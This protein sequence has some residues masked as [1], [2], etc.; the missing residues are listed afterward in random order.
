MPEAQDAA[1]NPHALPPAADVSAR[2]LPGC[3]MLGDEGGACWPLRIGRVWP[4]V[5]A[6]RGP[7]H[8]RYDLAGGPHG[9]EADTLRRMLDPQCW[10]TGW[11]RLL[12]IGA[13]TAEGPAWDALAALAGDGRIGLRVL[14]RWDRALLE[15]A[16]AP[17]ANAYFERFHSAEQRKALR[18][19]RR[20]LAES[21]ALAFR[22]FDDPAGIDAALALFCRLEAEGWKGRAGTALAQDPAGRAYVADVLAG[23]AGAGGAFAAV[24]SSGDTPLAAGLFLRA[25]GEVLFWKTAYDE[26]QSRH[27]PGVVFDV[28]LTEW[29]YAQ[30]WFERLDA[31]HDDSVDPATLIWRQRRP[32]ADLLIDLAPGSAAGR[33]ALAGLTLRRKLRAL[34]ARYP[35]K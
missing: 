12:A 9:M 4:G 15:R 34:K 35:T 31:G 2:L 22:L 20:R 10:P 11:P 8:P 5:A 18:R 30:P 14:A 21:G 13:M 33:L 27:S 19:K 6:L 25:G 23:M 32:M 28:L 29:L 1:L 16:A 24:L 26:R 7:R 17:D 3:V